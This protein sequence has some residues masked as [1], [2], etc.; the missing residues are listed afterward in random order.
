MKWCLAEH[1]RKRVRKALRTASSI[2]MHQDGRKGRILIRFRASSAKMERAIGVLGQVHLH[3]MGFSSSAKGV[4]DAFVFVVPEAATPTIPPL[5]ADLSPELLQGPEFQTDP[6]MI[7]NI[8]QRTHLFDADAAEDEQLS[9]KIL[10]GK[11]F[12]TEQEATR[13]QILELEPFLMNLLIR[14]CEKLTEHEG[15]PKE[16][17]MLI[18]FWQKCSSLRLQAATRWRNESSVLMYSLPVLRNV[19][20]IVIKAGLPSRTSVYEIWGRPRTDSIR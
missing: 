14:A 8:R 6:V 7:D 10:Q 2:S 11:R 19:F 15:S 17:S 20:V 4:R 9:A 5:L 16:L 1:K 3:E 12:A 18:N 13:A